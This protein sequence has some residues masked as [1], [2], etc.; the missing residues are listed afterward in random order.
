MGL[1]RY[2]RSVVSWLMQA[3]SILPWI[4]FG[5]PEEPPT[6]QIHEDDTT[7]DVPEPPELHEQHHPTATFHQERG[8]PKR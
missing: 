2:R 7:T 1:T 4:G 5:R 8:H 3:A 6:E